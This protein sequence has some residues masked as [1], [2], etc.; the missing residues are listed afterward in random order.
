MIAKFTRLDGRI[1]SFDPDQCISDPPVEMIVG[2]PALAYLYL[3]DGRCIEQRGYLAPGW[4]TH[5]WMELGGSIFDEWKEQRAYV[6]DAYHAEYREIDR[7]PPETSDEV[8]DLVTLDQAAAAVHRKKRTLER[9]KT[10]GT[11]PPPTVEGGGGK[12]DLWDWPVL[13]P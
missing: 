4:V 11:L 12:P 8:P 6:P 1:E 2:G 13:R 9:R 10:E 3:P 5:H 7:K